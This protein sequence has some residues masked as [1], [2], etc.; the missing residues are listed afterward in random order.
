M[1]NKKGFTLIEVITAIAVVAIISGPIL[2]LFLSSTR[3]GRDSYDT[4][5]Y[6]SIAVQEVETIKANP[7]HYTPP[8]DGTYS[9]TTYYNVNWGETGSSNYYYRTETTVDWA[10]DGVDNDSVGLSYIPQLNNSE[11]PNVSVVEYSNT[12]Q[13]QTYSLELTENRGTYTL[14]CAY[15]NYSCDIFPSYSGTTSTMTINQSEFD[16][17]ILPIVVDIDPDLAADIR[18]TYIIDNSTDKKP[19]FY[20]YGDKADSDKHV[21][22]IASS[23]SVGVTYMSVENSLLSF[24]ELEVTIEVYRQKD[25]KMVSDYSTKVYLTQ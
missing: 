1:L 17:D 25:D 5:K 10:E 7:E 13:E 9:M 23:G 19:I 18:M 3:V 6:H 15:S 22:A 8:E 20:V 24:N 14:E 12:L 4:D 2:Y 21:T 11:R 16:T